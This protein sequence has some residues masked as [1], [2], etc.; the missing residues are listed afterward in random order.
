M[1][2][3]G[4]KLQE[5]EALL[6]AGPK[7]GTDSEDLGKRVP[8]DLPFKDT[9]PTPHLTYPLPQPLTL[10]PDALA[11]PVNAGFSL[12]PQKSLRALCKRKHA[13][14]GCLATSRPSA[15]FAASLETH[16]HQPVCPGNLVLISPPPLLSVTQKTITEPVESPRLRY[17]TRTGI[18]W[19]QSFCG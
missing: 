12:S 17:N 2:H 7:Q 13:A 16:P 18:I 5:E 4:W 9:R 14:S 15:H 8:N 19:N 11:S 3:L 1:Q 10:F 6:R